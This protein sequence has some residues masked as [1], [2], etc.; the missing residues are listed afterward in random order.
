M[1]ISHLCFSLSFNLTINKTHACKTYNERLLGQELFEDD[2]YKLCTHCNS[3]PTQYTS[4]SEVCSQPRIT[5]SQDDD[6]H[7]IMQIL[8]LTASAQTDPNRTSDAQA[9]L[10]WRT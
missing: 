9:G 10:P 3:E 5:R 1:G 8:T 4:Q 6:G 7:F 2:I